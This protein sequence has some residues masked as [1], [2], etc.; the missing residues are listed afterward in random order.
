MYE[1]EE[2]KSRKTLKMQHK[3]SLEILKLYICLRQIILHCS[4]MMAQYV[5]GM[6]PDNN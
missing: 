6:E 1:P 3:F 2:T 5:P 4:T